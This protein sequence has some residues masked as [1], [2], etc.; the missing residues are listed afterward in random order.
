MAALCFWSPEVIRFS[1]DR[2]IEMESGFRR[3]FP[4]YERFHND[5]MPTPDMEGID[6]DTLM[7]ATKE[8]LTNSYD[9]GGDRAEKNQRPYA[10]H[11]A[12][13][14]LPFRRHGKAGVA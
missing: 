9:F 5:L 13:H 3:V 11:V 7:A 14:G 2:E 10:C 8:L 12:G 1:V 4:N 6:R